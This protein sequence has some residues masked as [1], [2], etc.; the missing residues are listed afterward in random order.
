[1]RAIL[2]AIALFTLF[3]P[4]QAQELSWQEAN[5]QSATLLDAG[6]AEEAAPLARQAAELYPSQSNAYK[7]QNHAQLVLNAVEMTQIAE[8]QEAAALFLED[9]LKAIEA[10]AGER[11][12]LLAPLS[13]KA[14]RMFGLL[15]E[16]GKSQRYYRR[17]CSLAD[18]IWGETDPRSILYY[19]NWGHDLRQRFGASWANGK[20]KTA[21]KRAETH[22][23]DNFLVLRADLLLAKIR[24]ENGKEHSAIHAYQELVDRLEQQP[25]KDPLLLQSSYA[26]LAYAYNEIGDDEALDTILGKF[27]QTFSG[28]KDDIQ[29]LIR[30]VPVYPSH[31]A[32]IGREG[33]VVV[34]FTLDKLGR[35]VGPKIIESE[36]GREFER[37]ALDA[38][39]NW[40]YRPQ[41]ID[42]EPQVMENVQTLLT[43][44]LK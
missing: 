10:K 16:Y 23:E 8:G 21:R 32:R 17:A 44:D 18:D 34:E 27:G 29:P 31:A 40:R 19:M 42:G 6:N 3:L 5:R 37:S 14:A 39:E 15:A 28:N 33:Y 2:S 35:V 11:E 20:L 26:H 22:G 36:G 41:L 9:A 43:F 4:V 7:P 12:I 38:I 24:L 1:M 30:V 13:A 25:E